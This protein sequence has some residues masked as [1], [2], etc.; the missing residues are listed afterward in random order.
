M[1]LD[2]KMSTTMPYSRL[3]ST[4]LSIKFNII[5]VL[6]HIFFLVFNLGQNFDVQSFVKKSMERAGGG[7]LGNLLPSPNPA[8]IE[9]FPSRRK[10]LVPQQKWWQASRRGGYSVGRCPSQAAR[11]HCQSSNALHRQKIVHQLEWWQG[12]QAAGAGGLHP[13]PFRPGHSSYRAVGHHLLGLGGAGKL[14]A[15]LVRV[16]RA[17]AMGTACVVNT[18]L[19]ESGAGQGCSTKALW[20]MINGTNNCVKSSGNKPSRDTQARRTNCAKSG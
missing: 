6:P 2:V 19:W 17:Q 4:E 5:V 16:S 12:F 9:H 10:A 15:V 8:S 11:C 7:E 14:E 18:H 20:Q 13:G 3:C 1:G